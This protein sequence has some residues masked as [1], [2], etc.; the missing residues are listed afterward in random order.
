MKPRVVEK[1]LRAALGDEFE[2]AFTHIDPEPLAA[3]SIG[4]VHR[5]VTRDGQPVA[6]KVQYPGVDAAIAADLDNTALLTSMLGFDYAWLQ[7]DALNVQH[8]TRHASNAGPYV[9]SKTVGGSVL[10]QLWGGGGC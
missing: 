5:A 1:Q 9:R 6:V 8:R 7:D 4:Q 2:R 10:A 3:A